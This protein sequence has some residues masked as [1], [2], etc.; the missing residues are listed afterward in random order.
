MPSRLL[1]QTDRMTRLALAAAEEALADAGVDTWPSC[2]TTR[3]GVVTASSAGGFDFGQREL[4]A[5]WTQGRP[6]RQRVPVLRLV[7]RGQHR[8]DLH[9]ARAARPQ[10]GPGHRAGGRP[11]RRGPGPAPAPQGPAAP[12]LRGGGLLALPLGLGRS[13]GR[14]L[15]SPRART[16]NAPTCP[17]PRTPTAMSP[18][19]GGAMLVVEDAAAARGTRRAR[20][21]GRS[22]D[23]R[24]PST[25]PPAP[26]ARP[27]CGRRRTGPARRR[28]RRRGRGRR[29]RGR[30]RAAHRR[31][32]GGRGPHRPLRRRT[33]CR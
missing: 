13:P 25:R 27:G 23:T 2:P 9:P 33:A 11:G 18:G 22:P 20:S 15:N 4:E 19:E 26:V 1:P 16:R 29:L 6:V 14:R 31:P 21:T 17:S 7:L 3:A 28:A 5:L 30:G 12:G 8:P 32:G 24:P 10:R